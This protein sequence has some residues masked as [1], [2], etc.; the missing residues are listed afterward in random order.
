MGDDL[1]LGFGA[2]SSSSS[3]ISST[4]SS[5]LSSSSSSHGSHAS[6]SSATANL[7]GRAFSLT[8]YVRRFL[9][10]TIKD[11]GKFPSQTTKKRN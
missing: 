7:I 9:V 11:E 2:L 5:T 8:M 4:S 3:P 10:F 1:G 6:S